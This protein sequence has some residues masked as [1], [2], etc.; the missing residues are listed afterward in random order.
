MVFFSGEQA[1]KKIHKICE[2]FGA[3]CYPVP[4]DSIKRRQITR[5][6]CCQIDCFCCCVL[7]IQYLCL[8]SKMHGENCVCFKKMIA[9]DALHYVLV[10]NR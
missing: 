2:A 4:E 3:N 10:E 9:I 7:E 8:I 6:V 5:D 1:R